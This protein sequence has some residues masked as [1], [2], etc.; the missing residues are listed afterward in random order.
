MKKLFK[1]LSAVLMAAV[2]TVGTM[3]MT[4]YAA[5]SV[6][7]YKGRNVGFSFTPGSEYT[8][9]DLFENFKNVM[10]GD[11][12]REQ[13]TIENDY[14]GSD[15]IR[16]WMSAILHDKRQDADGNPISSK[17]LAELDADERKGRGESSLDYMHDFLSQ[18]T[19]T[20]K[21]GDEVVYSGHPHSL[22]DGFEGDNVYLGYLGRKKNMK[23][24]VELSVDIEMGNEYAN[25]I[26][27]VDWIFLVEE[28]NEPD[29]D[30][31]KP[32]GGSEPDPTP[33]P[34]PKPTPEKPS[35]IITDQDI[36]LEVLPEMDVPLVVLPKTGDE[37]N[38]APWLMLLGVGVFGM[39]AAVFGTRKKKE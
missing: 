17:V 39:V 28:Y 38:A 13:V 11:V 31:D 25:R 23:L 27:E 30:D 22:A 7:T 10:P 3:S 21:N 32:G 37:T 4:S 9:T 26:G 19:L 36:P 18:L 33:K 20:V 5:E 8:S 15:G 6:I 35:V 16:V 2:L 29:D 24:D 34:K 1:K 12:R 14:T